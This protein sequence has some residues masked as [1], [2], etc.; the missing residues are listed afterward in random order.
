MLYCRLL[1]LLYNVVLLD[2]RHTNRHGCK[3]GLKYSSCAPS[4]LLSNKRY[5]LP[6]IRAC[7][8]ATAIP[9]PF[10]FQLCGSCDLF[11]RVY[12]NLSER[13]QVCE[14]CDWCCV[15]VCSF[16]DHKFPSSPHTHITRHTIT[17]THTRN[18]HTH[19]HTA[20]AH[21]TRIHESRNTPTQIFLITRTYTVCGWSLY[22]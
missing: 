7:P 20:H 4:T 5:S 8:I 19:T 21:S 6:S 2:R 10:I 18:T 1:L 12:E 16:R 11:V 9:A 14:Q 3:N 17:I 15:Y 22:P 13:A